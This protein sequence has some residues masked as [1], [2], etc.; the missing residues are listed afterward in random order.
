M[1]AGGRP[2]GKTR[3]ELEA[4]GGKPLDE[5]TDFAGAAQAG[6]EGLVR[7]A[8]FGLLDPTVEAYSQGRGEAPGA[9][10]ARREAHPV[11]AGVGEVA[12]LFT[13]GP[14]LVG[15]VGA[16]AGGLA[17]T[18][19]GARL[20]SGATEGGLWGLS[21]AMNEEHMNNPDSDG[22]HIAAGVLGGALMG[23]G[24]NTVFGKVG[25]LGKSALVK[26]FGGKALST[27]LDSLAEQAVMRSIAKPADYGN[28]QLKQRA[29][30]V[31]RQAIDEGYTAGI[32]SLE[33]AS[34]RA[35]T[36]VA[37]LQGQIQSALDQLDSS[38]AKFDPVRA[39]ARLQPEID[40]MG[41]N[42]SLTGTRD[43]LQ[44]FVDELSGVGTPAVPAQP[45]FFNGLRVIDPKTGLQAMSVPIP[46]V[47]GSGPETF[48]KAW[49]T[50]REASADKHPEVFKYLRQEL[51]QELFDQAAQS[52]PKLS[53]ALKDLSRTQANALEFRTL[54]TQQSTKEGLG[55]MALPLAGLITHGPLGAATGFAVKAGAKVAG[56]R[57]GFAVAS[58]LDAL[59]KNGTLPK[60]AQGFQLLMK[61]RLA[62]VGFGGP[63]R[64]VLE[65]A[66]AKGAMD[67]LQTHLSLAK[68]DPEYL[69]AVGLEPEDP[70]TVASHTD[71]ANRLAGLSGGLGAASQEIDKSVGRLLG[72]QPGRAPIV[73]NREPSQAEY[74][75]MLKKLKILG[76]NAEN[77]Q[78]L[79]DLAPNTA[80]A[81]QMTTLN[82]AKYLLD[83][84]PVNPYEGLPP[85]L[86]RPW[87]P[88]KGE[89]R[90][91][92]RRV[93]TVSD[94]RSVLESMSQGGVTAEQVATL[95]AVYPKIH[96]EFQEKMRER[97][98]AWDKPLNRGQ[99]A[100]VS[101][102]LGDLED[103]AVTQ[104]IQAVHQ[105]SIPPMAGKP[106]QRQNIDAAKNEQTQ[107]Q[108]M[109]AK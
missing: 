107:A 50:V 89:L 17:K 51:R 92:F 63:F 41:A 98:S 23:M 48:N 62:D 87:M 102:L 24:V 79:A 12:G 82:A 72:E 59:A 31:A 52:N 14:G 76:S 22:E 27:S 58:A 7:S 68:Q 37:Q 69:Q 91:W 4:M 1:A 5:P 64:A 15:K 66:S 47:P 2:A 20:I 74:E 81:A 16:A 11:A 75:G 101:L 80:I 40:A 78:H 86:Q 53:V 60:I 95:Q 42:P 57:G 10:Q 94:P 99:R 30:A 26:A 46:G 13:P 97:L 8:S 73:K 71:R 84:A 34:G 18:V 108:R 88:S 44:K 61:T 36:H 103:P 9:V 85:A 67:L 25:D 45:I 96:K 56:E 38:G 3:A 77:N 21:A 100:Q 19:R 83:Q 33:K 90:S 32:P 35:N 104:L 54:A 39:A 70:S 105:R 6:V 49:E 55:G 106:D 65:T 29:G 28:R 43:K 109:E 93:A